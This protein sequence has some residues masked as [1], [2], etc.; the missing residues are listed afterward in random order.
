MGDYR[1]Y[2][3]DGVPEVVAGAD[4]AALVVTHL[5]PVDGDVVVVTSKIVSKAEGRVRTGDREA[6]IDAETVRLVA[7][8]GPTRIVQNRLGLVMAAAGVDAS[9]VELGSVLLLPEDPDGTARSIRA[10]VRELTGV[11]VAVIITDTAGRAWRTGQTDIAIGVA[12]LAPLEEYAGKVDDYGNPLA[13]TAP[14][15]ADEIAS[16]AELAQGKLAGRPLALIRGLAVVL[17]AGEDGPGAVALQR[18]IDQDMFALGAREA[19][20]AALSGPNPAFGA[21]TPPE[22]LLDALADLDLPATLSGDEVRLTDPTDRQVLRATLAAHA[23]GWSA[24]AR[25]R[26]SPQKTR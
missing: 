8:R 26:F 7:R 23:H 14:A 1:V 6:V 16:A 21:P 20:L 15:V 10:T 13:V 19:V 9:N 18:P 4:L 12:G 3:P 2:S 25:G 11:N 22:T 24:S 17:P 5:D